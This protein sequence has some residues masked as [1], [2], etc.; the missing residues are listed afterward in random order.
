MPQNSIQRGLRDA[1]SLGIGRYNHFLEMLLSGRPLEMLLNELVLLIQE[2]Q[3]EC[4]ASILLLSDDGKHLIPGAAPDLPDFYVAAINNLAIGEGVGSCGTAAA[5]A[6]LVIVE[7]IQSHPY[8]Q[9]YRELAA[10]AGLYA[11]W[12]QPI[13]GN[14]GKVLGV[15]GLYYRE[16][17]HPTGLD[18][19]LIHE[20]ARLAQAS[21]EF[22][23]AQNHR[24]LTETITQHL[25]LGLII[26]DKA[27]NIVE[28]NPAFSH[29]TGYPGAEVLGRKPG[30]FAADPKSLQQY[31]DILDK[32]PAWR[33]W[34]T[35]LL[36]SRRNG[37]RFNA[38]LCF[39][40]VRDEQS[41]ILRYVA[42]ISDISERKRSEETIQYQASYDLLTS[43][44]N[45]NLFYERLNWT[46][47]Q[48][49]RKQRS[50][51]VL[52]MDLD[53]FKEIND[54]LGHDAGDEL[55]VKVGTRL[56][57]SM[58]SQDTIARLG[59]DEFG[60]IITG[61]HDQ[62]A[63]EQLADNILKNV[64]RSLT[65]RQMRNCRITSSIGISCYPNDGGTLEQLLK[66]AEQAV[67]A[68]KN[69]GRNGYA[70]F[71]PAMFE[72]AKT[73]ALLHQEMHFAVSQNQLELHYQPIKR[74]TDNCIVQLEALVRWNHPERGLV[75]PDLF[76][77]LA[78]KTGM[79]RE[80]GQWVRQEALAMIGRMQQ[81]GLS[82]PI[83][84]NDSTAE[85]YDHSLADKIIAQVEESGVARG[86]LLV[87][88]TESLLI[89]NQ[90]ETCAFLDKLQQAGIRVALDDF[91]T[92]F[93]SLSYLAAFPADKLK[94]DRSF[95][96]Q[97]T[98]NRRKESLV[99]TI[100]TLGHSLNMSV[101][102]EGVETEEEEA[103][104]RS[105][106]CDNV[107]GFLLAK[108]LPE[109]DLIEFLR[110]YKPDTNSKTDTDS[111]PGINNKS[112]GEQP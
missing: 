80:I 109:A 51:S 85:F 38:E 32:L 108:P 48:G 91:G 75:R 84:A 81:Q 27:F 87:E 14:N 65:I 46:L 83:A 18:L 58:R 64:S 105:K 1:S 7:D 86:S 96:H 11:C 53:Y 90:Q 110:S 52:L 34:T 16:V 62:Q 82:V 63:L 29:I 26:T 97:M 98:A 13:V 92:G 10:Q 45:R 5:T 99:D 24:Q 20:A 2:K 28:V 22:R 100:I 42:L 15:F 93:S 43:L 56:Q 19:L 37:E 33:S 30:F 44:P 12:S 4:I 25:P 57:Q 49:R 9:D 111:K 55:L 40:V 77:P 36:I 73:Q 88:I 104:L 78:E 71:T 6:R 50:F 66:A 102:A 31:R 112:D 94:I 59:G 103:L 89:R 54:T 61:E 107:Q 35:E 95:V 21:I 17:R 106:N 8:W 76:I 79:I 69:A 41:N 74:L 39:S 101:I 70:F 23:R 3:P 67:Y 47:E 60:F 68:A 72:A